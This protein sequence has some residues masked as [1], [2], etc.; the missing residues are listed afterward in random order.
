MAK[1]VTPCRSQKTNENIENCFE[2]FECAIFS[3]IFIQLTYSYK[4]SRSLTAQNL[5]IIKKFEIFSEPI[6]F[7]A[8]KYQQ[9][10]NRH[11]NDCIYTRQIFKITVLKTFYSFSRKHLAMRNYGINFL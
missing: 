10:V 11:K 5:K 1:K 3:S 7:R 8:P 4:S 2:E 9:H 6:N